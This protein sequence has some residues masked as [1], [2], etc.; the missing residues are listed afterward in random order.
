MW[1]SCQHTASQ[2]RTQFHIA[3]HEYHQ[4][5][6]A[7]QGIR[8]AVVSEPPDHVHADATIDAP[9]IPSPVPSQN[10]A[11]PSLITAVHLEDERPHNLPPVGTSPAHQRPPSLH[12]DHLPP[13][14]Q[15]TNAAG[16]SI[17]R[18]Y[19]DN[20]T[21]HSLSP[22]MPTSTE[23]RYP[24]PSASHQLANTSPEATHS[25]PSEYPMTHNINDEFQSGVLMS[26]LASDR[27]TV[28]HIG[29]DI[30]SESGLGSVFTTLPSHTLPTCPLDEILHKFLKSRKDMIAQGVPIE[31]V[32]GPPKPTVKALLN[33]TMT[34]TVHPLSGVM[35][36]V[37]S[38]FPH[39]DQPE[40]LAFFY[41]MFKTMRVIHCQV[42]LSERMLIITVANL[43]F[44][45]EL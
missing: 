30:G 16:Y 1:P 15:S 11:G 8:E 13:P 3:S 22:A 24:S 34:G 6:R 45:R 38:T 29:N 31:T 17:S 32:V 4:T 40:K 39:V 12:S 10:L 33:T 7:D 37:L 42:V 21:S 23:G 35:S 36:E 20:G 5:F 19:N 27:T 44:K 43:P 14:Q 28:I 18:A 9:R 26:P 2:P 41:L 25:S